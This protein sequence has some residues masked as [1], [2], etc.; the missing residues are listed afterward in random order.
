MVW[1]PKSNDTRPFSLRLGVGVA[2]FLGREVGGRWLDCFQVSLS[3][4]RARETGQ[5]LEREMERE[6][7]G[8]AVSWF[9]CFFS[10]GF[11]PRLSTFV[12]RRATATVARKR[13]PADLINF[14]MI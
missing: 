9:V 3:R 12:L 6:I 5:E 8:V 4:E 10:A 1:R 2:G 14:E 13:R 7:S 11:W